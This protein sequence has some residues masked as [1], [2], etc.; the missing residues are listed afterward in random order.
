M[1]AASAYWA[2]APPHGGC[3]YFMTTTK[4][5]SAFFIDGLNLYFGVR[6]LYKPHLMWLDLHKLAGMFTGQQED[7][8]YINYFTSKVHFIKSAEK[9]Q[10]M[11]LNALNETDVTVIYGK[12]SKRR[13]HCNRPECSKAHNFVHCLDCQKILLRREEKQSDVALAVSVMYGALKDEYDKAYIISGDSD[14]VP[15][16]ESLSKMK[17]EAVLLYPPKREAK[18]L[19]KKRAYITALPLHSGRISS[20]RLPEVI[21][22]SP[23]KK[24][25][26]IGKDI[27][28]PADWVLPPKP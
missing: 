4:K 2:G 16:L 28:C 9:N 11:Y 24:T 6:R 5:R 26:K 1:H 20:C 25:G 18:D 15:L 22:R 23:N 17:K 10:A 7:L 8:K 21:K 13:H 12:F 14:M 19:K 3:V 27:E